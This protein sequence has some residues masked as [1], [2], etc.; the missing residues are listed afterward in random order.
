MSVPILAVPERRWECPSCGLLDVTREARAHTRMHPC[1]A[2]GGLTAPMVEAGSKA[3]HVAQ[4]RQDYVGKE[5]VQ[6]DADGRPVMAVTT[7]HAD[8][9]Q[10]CTVFAPT[11]SARVVE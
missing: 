1:P 3:R 2:L 5:Q 11:A 10:D 9:R 8:G 4:D 7:E 6:L